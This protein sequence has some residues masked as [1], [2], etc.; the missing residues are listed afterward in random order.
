MYTA[1][2]LF[3]GFAFYSLISLLVPVLVVVLLIKLI[4]HHRDGKHGPFLKFRDVV[5]A[6]LMA[7]AGFVGLAGLYVLP[8]VLFDSDA[9]FSNDSPSTSIFAVHLVCAVGLMIAGMLFQK[10]TGKFL[11]VVGL[12]LLITASFPALEGIGSAGSL[13]AV[14]AAFAVLVALTVHVSRKA[15]KNG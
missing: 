2:M 1:S 12:L 4:L 8:Y 3:A 7:A 15:A 10:V 5:L 14:I 6:T 11:M 13:I 9:L